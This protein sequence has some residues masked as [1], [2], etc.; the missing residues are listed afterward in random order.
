MKKSDDIKDLA[1]ALAKVQGALKPAIKDAI[2]PHF[3]S[4]YADLGS[5]W[6]SCRTLLSDNGLS[7]AQLT[8]G[9]SEGVIIETMLLH[10]SGQWLS[11]ELYLPLTKRDAQGVGSAMT[12]GR[13][14]GL[15][16]MVGIVA[17]V[18]DDG[19]AAS[20]K[21]DK[22][23]AKPP[24]QTKPPELQGTSYTK[25]ISAIC[26]ELNKQSGETIKWA[27]GTLADYARQ[28]FHDDSIKSAFGMP[29]NDRKFLLEDL[30]LRLKTLKEAK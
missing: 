23:Q 22:Q 15:A 25:E 9:D 14:Y 13:R 27:S 26:A 17:D 1:I 2:N 24:A 12:Y 19:N 18:D 16:A 11:S 29:E 10:S 20:G 3:R 21:A 6:D 8:G 5:I 28:L 4:Q 7:V 30:Q